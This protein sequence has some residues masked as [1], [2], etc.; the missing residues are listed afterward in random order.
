MARI[1]IESIQETLSPED[2]KILSTEYKNLDGELTFQCPEGHLV[3]T[4]W[5]KMRTKR[6]CPVCKQNKYKEN[7]AIVR[8]KQ[9]G[10]NRV[11][12]L[13]QASRKTGFALMDGIEL[14]HYGVFESSLSDEA[15]RVHE[16]KEWVISMIENWKPDL[17]AIEGIQYEQNF[18]VTTFQTLARLQGVLIEVCFD[19][20]VPYEVVSSNTWRAHC[21]VKGR[22]RP[23]KKR[24]MQL[25]IKKWY[26]VSV[27]D[28]EADA[29]GLCKY[30]ADTHKKRT[31]IISWE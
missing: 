13:D 19:L 2:W 6:E 5:S 20:K 22:S 10:E 18:G 24:S 11:L 31:E 25:N 7:K 16:I 12:A 27:S 4:S 28:D 1:T 8:E 26:D 14:V 29:I 17:I 3:Y 30:A 9:K 23:D 21:E 15:A